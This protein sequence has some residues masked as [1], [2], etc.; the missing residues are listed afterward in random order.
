MVLLFLFMLLPERVN[1]VS[2]QYQCVILNQPE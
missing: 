1:D 2:I